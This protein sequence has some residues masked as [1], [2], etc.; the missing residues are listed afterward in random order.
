MVRERQHLFRI[1]DFTNKK[2]WGLLQ[3]LVAAARINKIVRRQALAAASLF[4][5]KK[6][7]VLT[8]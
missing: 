7:K 1:I 8:L 6:L 5:R 4:K 2:L 3:P